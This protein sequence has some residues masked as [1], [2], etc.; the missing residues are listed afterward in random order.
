MLRNTHIATSTSLVLAFIV[1][2]F[3]FT[4]LWSGAIFPIYPFLLLPILAVLPDADHPEWYLNVKFPIFKVISKIAGHRTW[5]H[6]LFTLLVVAMGLY[7]WFGALFG[8]YDQPTT[9]LS[10]GFMWWLKFFFLSPNF[11]GIYIAMAGHTFGDFLTKGTVKFF[12]WAEFLDEKFKKIA[13]LRYTLWLPFLILSKIQLFLNTI[14]GNIFPTTGSV[15]E[16]NIYAAIFNSI[17]FLLIILL[18]F[19]FPVANS[20]KNAFAVIA[21][22]ETLPLKVILYLLIF[23][24]VSIWYFFSLTVGKLKFYAKIAKN[25]ILFAIGM[26]VGLVAVYFAFTTIPFLSNY[27]WAGVVSYMILAIIIYRKTV[28]VEFDYFNVIMNE[29][30]IIL[31]YCIIAW[32]GIYAT[33]KPL[34]VVDITQP[35]TTKIINTL[36]LNNTNNTSKEIEKNNTKS[37]LE[38]T[39]STKKTTKI[40]KKKSTTTTKKKNTSN[41]SFQD[42]DFQ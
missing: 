18:A 2:C 10:D 42:R 25:M 24:V 12:Y 17:N 40:T 27:A 9:L 39:S 34:K 30:F 32:I 36:H 20:L 21:N 41:S 4:A 22:W 19:F 26:L 35:D 1:S 16:K 8:Y 11:L 7:W 38:D 29:I 13:F 23:F 14:K 15:F 28:R 31:I 6:D 5:S 37:N 3:F 33:T